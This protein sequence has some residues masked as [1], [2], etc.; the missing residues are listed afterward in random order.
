MNVQSVCSP[1]PLCLQLV[2]YPIFF[3]SNG[4]FLLLL[5]MCIKK[6]M[7]E[8]LLVVQMTSK[9]LKLLGVNDWQMK[10]KMSFWEIIIFDTFSNCNIYIYIYIYIYAHENLSLLKSQKLQGSNN[11]FGWLPKLENTLRP[12][13][14]NHFDW[15]SLASNPFI[16]GLNITTNHR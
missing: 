2:F 1:I 13:D 10:R 16:D 12:L 8:A 5:S 3:K 4:A 11:F 15:S 9:R 14:S 6:N 7:F